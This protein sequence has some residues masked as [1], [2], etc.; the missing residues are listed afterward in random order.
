MTAPEVETAIEI[1]LARVA[2]ELRAV[3]AMLAKVKTT[4]EFIASVAVA[5]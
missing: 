4:L 2:G 5:K 3:E 1:A